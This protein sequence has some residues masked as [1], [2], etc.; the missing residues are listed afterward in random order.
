MLTVRKVKLFINSLGG[1][2]VILFWI[3]F[4]GGLL[5]CD[6]SLA[7]QTWFM[8]YWAEQY[9]IYLPE[10]VNITLWVDTP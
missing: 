4:A 2:H 5:L 8:G 7:A 10:E 6:A 3:L 1:S 9:D